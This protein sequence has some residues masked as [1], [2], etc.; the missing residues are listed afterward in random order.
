MPMATPYLLFTCEHASAFVP[1]AHAKLL[2][3]SKDRGTHRELDIGGL[4]TA[5]FLARQFVAPLFFGRISR[6]LVDMNRSLA[7]PSVLSPVARTLPEPQQLRLL[8]RY[9]TKH[10]QRIEEHI[11]ASLRSHRQVVHIAVHS[12]T[13]AL[14]HDDGRVETRT[15]DMGLLYDPRR[16]G[17][18][19]LA[20]AWLGTLRD[21]DPQLR[22][23]R[24]YPYQGK[25]DGLAT[26]L[27]KQHGPSRYVGFE[28]EVNQALLTPA[29]DPRVLA[30][31]VA[32]LAGLGF[33][34]GTHR[35]FRY[36]PE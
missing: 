12:F 11:N 14:R 20:K 16:A 3:G 36:V 6:L 10:W 5:K 27:R 29:P 33:G 31:L 1:V 21:A 28:L 8:A 19:T 26:S 13:P 18:R 32:S 25:G 4:A 9:H 35:I 23:R 17:E 7:N 22:V 15:A 24:N 30:A 2:R 34:K